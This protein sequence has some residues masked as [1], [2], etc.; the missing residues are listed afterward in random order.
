MV[1]RQHYGKLAQLQSFHVGDPGSNPG[2]DATKSSRLAAL[3]GLGRSK[4]TPMSPQLRE[5][6]AERALRK[7]RL[8]DDGCLLWRGATDKH[9]FGRFKL[10]KKLYSPH[11]VVLERHLKR[12]LRHDEDAR[13]TCGRHGCLALEHLYVSSRMMTVRSCV[14]E[15]RIP[16]GTMTKAG[17]AAIAA[18][19]RR[20][21]QM[22]RAKA[23]ELGTSFR[24][25][26]KPSVP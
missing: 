3:N 16:K 12:S 21:A 26:K 7:A 24:R 13:Q 15:G 17:R 1:T 8:T 2:G 22:V 9:G 11:R 5:K 23:A 19:N 14:R 25:W 4:L 6:L 10:A 20:R 18:S